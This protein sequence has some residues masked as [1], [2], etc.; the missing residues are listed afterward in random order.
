MKYIFTLDES[1]Q[2]EDKLNHFYASAI[3]ALNTFP[4]K[5]ESAVQLL[6]DKGLDIHSIKN[7]ETLLELA[8]YTFGDDGQKTFKYFVSLYPVDLNFQD[9]DGLTILHHAAQSG[10]Q[11][12]FTFFKNLGVD[13]SIKSNNNKTAGEILKSVLNE[14]TAE[15]LLLGSSPYI[16]LLLSSAILALSIFYRKKI[17]HIIVRIIVSFL[18]TLA[19]FYILST[20]FTVLQDSKESALEIMALFAIFGA[21]VVLPVFF[22]IQY[23][24][25]RLLKSKK[26]SAT[27]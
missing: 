20:V 24:I 22:I 7:K 15:A 2:Q 4:K 17:N 3:H 1:L 11:E 14:R 19:I 25:F 12:Q 26:H 23:L 5:N 6:V 27:F 18:D 21:V 10:N 13:A 16:L 9:E 8:K